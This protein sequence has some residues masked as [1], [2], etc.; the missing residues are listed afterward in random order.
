MPETCRDWLMKEIKDKYCTKLVFITKIT[1]LYGQQNIKTNRSVMTAASYTTFRHSMHNKFSKNKNFIFRYFV[2]V[3][4]QCHCMHINLHIECQKCGF[5]KA[6][7]IHVISV[8]QLL[9]HP[10]FIAFYFFCYACGQGHYLIWQLHLSLPVTLLIIVL[11][12]PSQLT[13]HIPAECWYEVTH[14]SQIN[15]FFYV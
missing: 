8:Q 10:A 7:T 6:V 11:M 5:N 12:W 13:T 9:G 4:R 14:N 15:K 2:K 3:T 1:K